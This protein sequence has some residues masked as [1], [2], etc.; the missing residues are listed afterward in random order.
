MMHNV[1]KAVHDRGWYLFTFCLYTSTFVCCI[2]GVMVSMLTSSALD[3]G[4]ES[5]SDQTKDYKFNY[6]CI[7]ANK[8][9]EQKLVGS[10][11]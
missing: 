3:Y 7:S 6:C 11:T 5:R 1:T 2:S 4:F 10:E 8:E 9:K